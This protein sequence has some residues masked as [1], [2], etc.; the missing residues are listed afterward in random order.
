MAVLNCYK[1]EGATPLSVL[2]SIKLKDSSLADTLMTYAGRLDP[3]ADGVLVVL[4]GDDRLRRDE[5]M[6]LNKTYQASF[7]FGFESDSYDALGLVKRGQ[8][9]QISDIERELKDLVGVHNLPF[10]PYSSYKVQGKPL[11]WWTKEGRLAE[12]E[13]PTKE[14]NV[15]TV[16]D[17]SLTSITLESALANIERRIGLVKG[18]FRQEEILKQWL[19]ALDVVKNISLAT[20]TLE[21]SSGTYIR[22]LAH[23]LGSRLG[24]GALLYSLTRTKV[25]NYLLDDSTRL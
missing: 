9:C 19:K 24:C 1:P 25:G 23:D 7:L 13:I 8:D 4:T 21:V 20:A 12:I 18:D 3:M 14:M 5:F 2:D 17:V 6:A 16:S 22:A 15:L 10:P 11:H